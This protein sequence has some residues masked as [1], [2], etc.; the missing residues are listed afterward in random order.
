MLNVIIIQIG[1]PIGA[2]GAVKLNAGGS[3]RAGQGKVYLLS[4]RDNVRT[5]DNRGSANRLKG[6]LIANVVRNPIDLLGAAGRQEELDF[7]AVYLADRPIEHRL[8]LTAWGIRSWVRRGW[9]FDHIG[10]AA[11]GLPIVA[12]GLPG[13]G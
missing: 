8:H 2:A 11:N 6:L 4:R 12:A 7:V 10:D 13:I 5:A 3:W 9:H 1:K